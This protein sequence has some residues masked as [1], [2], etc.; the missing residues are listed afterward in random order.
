MGGGGR[1]RTQSTV[2]R[3]LPCLSGCLWTICRPQGLTVPPLAP[4]DGFTGMPR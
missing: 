4:G 2:D 1:L 3:A